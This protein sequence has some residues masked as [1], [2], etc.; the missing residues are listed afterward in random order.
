VKVLVTGASGQLASSLAEIGKWREADVAT[1]GR[2]KLDVT[3]QDL[4]ADCIARVRPQIVVNAAA[5]TDVDG[6]ESDPILAHAVNA[7]GAGNVAAACARAGVPIIHISTDYVF[8]GGKSGPY[9]EDDT[10]TPINIYGRSK[11]EGEAHVA[12]SC[13]KHLILRT[14]WLYSPFGR[15]FARTMLRLAQERTA[16]PVVS[17]QVGTPTYAPHLAHTVLAAA[18]RVLASGDAS[19]WGT[20]HAAGMGETSWCGLAE[21]IFASSAARGGPAASIRPIGGTAYPTTAWR[22]A[23]SRLD[24]SKLKRTF[25]ITLPRWE[26]GVHACVARLLGRGHRAF[27]DGGHVP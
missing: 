5:F 20:Y 6:A 18:A 4:V 10:P 26:T 9:V 12:A 23:N 21:K 2:P 19:L 25:G 15:N 24:C 14:A 8:D 7:D 17:D 3:R 13:S 1:V 22:P 16:I 27:S 11:L